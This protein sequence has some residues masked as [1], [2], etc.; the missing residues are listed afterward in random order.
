MSTLSALL[1]RAGARRPVHD[2]GPPLTKG[3]RARM[4]NCAALRVDKR[5]AFVG[6]LQ[7]TTKLR[8]TWRLRF[9][10]GGR[11]YE[12]SCT[13]SRK[14]KRREVFADGCLVHSGGLDATPAESGAPLF[15]HAFE[16]GGR[17][18]AVEER[19]FAPDDGEAATGDAAAAR[20]AASWRAR[21]ASRSARTASRSWRRIASC[22]AS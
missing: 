3:D 1:G 21:P 20:E 19:V 22:M 6:R 17:R 13:A 5:G 10:P 2:Y 15:A 18:F 14:S 4:E 16:H 12:V 8:T 11:A 9:G 7:P